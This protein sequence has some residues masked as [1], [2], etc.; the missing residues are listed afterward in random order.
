MNIQ[1]YGHMVY[2]KKIITGVLFFM[3]LSAFV[4]LLAPS[5]SAHG[6]KMG[7]VGSHLSLGIFSHAGT[8]TAVNSN[9][10]TMQAKDDSSINVSTDGAK[11]IRLPYSVISLSNIAMGDHVWV[12]GNLIGNSIN[13]LVVHDL[14][15]NKEPAARK[16]TVTAVNGS[17]ITV[18]T[19][20]NGTI[21]VNTDSNTQFKKASQSAVLADVKVGSRVGIWGLWDKVLN[22]LSAIRIR[23]KA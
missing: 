2:M 5:A 17:T 19:K 1:P 9:G 18:Q 13:A 22:V 20:H 23:I 7:G 11:L 16:G 12:E 15:A 10:F 4:P 14:D 6:Y 3:V 8:V 21:T